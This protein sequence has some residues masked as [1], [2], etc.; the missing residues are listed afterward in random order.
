VSGF[1]VV[2]DPKVFERFAR[3][4]A[5]ESEAMVHEIGTK[6]QADIVTDIT[7][8]NLVAT[9]AY[10]DSI[11]LDFRKTGKGQ[12]AI[13]GSNMLHALPLEFGIT[14]TFYPSEDM[15]E[16]LQLW[17]RRK[18][19]LTGKEAER[20]GFLIAWKIARTAKT[21]GFPARFGTKGARVFNEVFAKSAKYIP[22]IIER[23][24]RRAA[25]L[26]EVN[27]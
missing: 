13:V 26:S 18:L 22:T 5:K 3:N 9:G 11:Q 19:G 2:L 25:A 24:T 15:I 17:S 6:L 14:K 7:R 20:A 27:P 10:R 4:M 12:L 23:F 21:R 8:K 1:T 16:S